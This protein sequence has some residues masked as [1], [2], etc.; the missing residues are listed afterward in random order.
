MV[1]FNAPPVEGV[2]TE[3]VAVGIINRLLQQTPP[4]PRNKLRE[5][6]HSG[7]ISRNF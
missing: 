5:L 7:G 3:V 4:H 2:E 1:S 6:I